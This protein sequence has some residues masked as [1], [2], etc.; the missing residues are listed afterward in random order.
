M[1]TRKIGYDILNG[2]K[3]LELDYFE[4]AF[5]RLNG[6][7][8]SHSTSRNLKVVVKS[9]M[10]LYAIIEIV[11]EIFVS[12]GLVYF[13]IHS[14]M[15]VHDQIIN[16]ALFMLNTITIISYIQWVKLLLM[17]G[18][19]KAV[20]GTVLWPTVFFTGGLLTISTGGIK[21]KRYLII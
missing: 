11:I 9:Q 13:H 19:R 1:M 17:F 2:I 3:K 5:M 20:I 10:M 21:M 14:L 6:Q 18:G 7:K 12:W 8:R 16:T 15:L 4:L